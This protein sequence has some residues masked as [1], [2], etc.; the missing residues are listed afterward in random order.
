MMI[1]IES[2]PNSYKS[3]IMLRFILA[4][5]VANPAPI[6]HLCIGYAHLFCITLR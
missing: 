6:A 4:R 5:K 2:D 3:L 1:F